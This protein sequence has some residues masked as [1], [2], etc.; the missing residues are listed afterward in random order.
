METNTVDRP[1]T[2][3]RR[4]ENERFSPKDCMLGALEQ[5]VQVGRPGR[6]TV[7]AAGT[8]WVD[9]ERAL[10]WP[11]FKDE[12]AFLATPS[13]EAQVEWVPV[14]ENAGSSIPLEELLWKTAWQASGGALLDRCQPYDVVE[15]RYWPNFTRLPHVD[16]LFPLCSLLSHRPSSLSFAR[17]MLRLPETDAFRFYSAATAAGLVRVVSAQPARKGSDGAS[18]GS[19]TDDREQGVGAFWGRL[20]KRISGL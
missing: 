2:A 20:F 12:D 15:L 13:A 7:P 8:V 17:R 9:P 6:L 4:S 16:S 1:Q 14:A 10:C 18:R 19:A 3:I 11:Q 5:L